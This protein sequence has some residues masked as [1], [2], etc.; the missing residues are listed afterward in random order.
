MVQTAKDAARHAVHDIV[1]R[2]GTS[3]FWAMRV[4]PRARRDAIFAIYAFCREV[5]DIADGD[6]SLASKHAALQAWRTEIARLYEGGPPA[7]VIG[8]A[9]GAAIADYGLPCDAFLAIIDG[10]EMDGQAIVAPSQETLMLYCARVAGAVGHLC[11]RVFGETGE[12][13]RRTAD[14]LG[15]AL[16]L[17]NILRDL[18]EDAARGRLYLPRELLKAHAI[19]LGVPGQVLRHPRI[20]AVC[21]TLAEQAQDAF[22]AAAQAIAACD[23]Q[24]HMRPAVIMMMVYKKTLARLIKSE[25]RHL[26][27]AATAPAPSVSKAE[28]LAIALR[29]GIF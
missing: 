29:H 22:R 16:Q 4:L 2:A 25:W 14:R 28:K 9:L 13:G 27:P 1:R 6:A 15:L 23:P 20:G 12:A 8:P 10:M 3:F 26:G 18:E 19:P 17:T 5:D 11:V 24:A 21:A 7:T